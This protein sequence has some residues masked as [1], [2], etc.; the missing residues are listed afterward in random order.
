MGAAIFALCG[1][2]EV[3]RKANEGSFTALFAKKAD[4]FF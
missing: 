4:S 3:V 1:R 2:D